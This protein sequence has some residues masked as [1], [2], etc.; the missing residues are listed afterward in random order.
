MPPKLPIMF[1]LPESVPAKRPPTS[2]QVAQVPGSV[3]SLAKPAKPIE[4]MANCG[5]L[6]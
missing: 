6:I 1:M 3:R 2:M 5:S 4:I